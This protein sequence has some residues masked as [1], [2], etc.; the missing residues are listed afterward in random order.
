MPL[1]SRECWD[2]GRP[3]NYIYMTPSSSGCRKTSRTWRRHS[4][5]ASRKS[6]PLWASDTSPG[7]GTCPPPINPASE[8]A[9][10]GAAKRAGGHQR[11]AIARESGDA[12]D[13]RR[14]DGLSQG[15]RRR[16]RGEPPGQHRRA[17]P[18]RTKKEDV[19]GRTPASC[20][21]SPAALEVPLPGGDPT[22]EAAER[23]WRYVTT[24]RQVTPSPPARRRDQSPR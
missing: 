5:R 13:P 18:W 20:S 16:H 1:R 10:C 2:S 17:R 7:V 21:A 14:L 23:I 19:V 22:C 3:R 6:T 9:W 24:I 4:G 12:V 8:R 15:H 11:R